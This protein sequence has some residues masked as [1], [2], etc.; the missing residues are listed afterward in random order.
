MSWRH[1]PRGGYRI[2]TIYRRRSIFTLAVVLSAG[3]CYHILAGRKAPL[4]S[5]GLRIGA[6]RI[7]VLPAEERR[8]S[9]RTPGRVAAQTARYTG[10]GSAFSVRTSGRRLAYSRLACGRAPLFFAD[11][12][13]V[14]RA[15]CADDKK[16]AKNARGGALVCGR[17][18][19]GGACGGKSPGS[20]AATPVAA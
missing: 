10:K 3:R 6:L 9:L 13:I 14:C 18:A 15:F 19:T 8:F 4:F 1:F 12:G 2:L 7:C 17:A 16:R 5:Y 20:S 11:A